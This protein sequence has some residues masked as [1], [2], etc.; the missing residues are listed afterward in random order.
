MNS[1]VAAE[2]DPLDRTDEVLRHFVAVSRPYRSHRD[3]FL[4]V[5]RA[6]KTTEP[7]VEYLLHAITDELG[8]MAK[9]LPAGRLSQGGMAYSTQQIRD[10]LDDLLR[11]DGLTHAM[12]TR[13]RHFLVDHLGIVLLDFPGMRFTQDWFSV[14][15][16]Q[17]SRHFGYHAGRAGQR[18]LEIGSF[19]GRSACWLLSTL[20][21]G[22]ECLLVCV[23]PFDTYPEQ[24][25]NFDHNIRACEAGHRTLK[26]RGRSQFVLPLLESASFDFI[27][28]DGSHAALDVFADAAA[29]WRL[30][31]SGGVIVFDDYRASAKGPEPGS[32]GSAVDG[33]LAT[34]PGQFEV[35]FSD[36]QLA[37]K[38]EVSSTGPWSTAAPGLAS[39]A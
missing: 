14:H 8:R 33:F 19:E 36:W 11:H 1:F 31:R 28:V 38:K 29:A 23:D 37:V 12:K 21:V 5:M 4:G 3:R 7:D 24:E 6:G 2:P 27:Y 18:F 9:A 26:L 35:L 15:E 20:L 10:L 39:Q 30:A 22:P 34:L 16:H 32:A 17:W 13:I 25:R